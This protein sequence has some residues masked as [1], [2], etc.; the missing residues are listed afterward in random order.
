MRKLSDIQSVARALG[1]IEALNQRRVSPLEDIHQAPGLPK[2]PLVRIL[3]T[4][5]HLG[6]VFHVSRRDGYALTEKILRLSAGFQHSDAI[7]DTPRPLMEAFPARHRWQLSLATLEV[8]AM[9]V[10]FNTRHMSP[11][12]PE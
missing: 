3:G 9:R 6:F 4:L 12:A 7:V 5:E 2:P 10:R 1:V 8:D 11:F